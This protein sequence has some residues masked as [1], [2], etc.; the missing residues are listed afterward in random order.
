VNK[1]D[2]WGLC[3]P[4]DNPPCY[5][6]T[7][8]DA[9]LGREWQGDPT[10]GNWM[11]VALLFGPLSGPVHQ[12]LLPFDPLSGWAGVAF[13]LQTDKLVKANTTKPAEEF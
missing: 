7:G 5:S 9:A 11:N 3:S 1:T 13:G 12:P 4:Q 2:P 8:T 10:A 6:V